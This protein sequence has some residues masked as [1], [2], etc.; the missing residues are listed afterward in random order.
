VHVLFCVLA[1]AEAH[2][3]FS[4]RVRA[5]TSVGDCYLLYTHIEYSPHDT[6]SSCCAQVYTMLNRGSRSGSRS[7]SMV[8]IICSQSMFDCSRLSSTRDTV[9]SELDSHL[10]W[11][12][13]TLPLNMLFLSSH[14]DI[15]AGKL[16]RDDPSCKKHKLS[17][18]VSSSA[19]TLH[20]LISSQLQCSLPAR[21]RVPPTPRIL[22]DLGK[23]R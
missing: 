1:L 18:L 13:L 22:D 14:R 11:P 15:D 19:S 3:R 8:S 20:S 12:T 6:Q 17:H 9:N 4:Y 21:L 7:V 10:S 2:A 23:A 16:M 5:C